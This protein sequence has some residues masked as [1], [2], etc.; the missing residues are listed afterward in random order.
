MELTGPWRTI[1]R[2]RELRKQMS[3][4]ERMLW[5]ALRG[6]QTG[7]RFRRQHPAGPYVLDFY[8]HELNLCLEVDGESHDFRVRHDERR[9]HWLELQGVRTLRIAARDILADTDTAVRYVIEMA[10]APSVALRAPPPPEGEE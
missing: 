6:K 7:Y 5:K 10:Q 3:L 1:E 4:P 2:A 9:D 8:C